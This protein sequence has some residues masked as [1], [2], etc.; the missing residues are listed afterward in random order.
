[1]SDQ[2][3]QGE[4]FYKQAKLAFQKVDPK[5]GEVVA[6]TVPADM[7]SIQVQT[8]MELLLQLTEELDCK[9]MVLSQG[10]QL[11]L[12]SEESMNQMGWYHIGNPAEI[13]NETRH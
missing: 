13:D 4:K 7:S 10:A 11:T 5:H 12:I 6:V 3:T 8:M 1:M 9:A 2:K